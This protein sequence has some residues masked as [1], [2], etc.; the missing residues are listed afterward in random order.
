MN[1]TAE[2][3]PMANPTKHPMQNPIKIKINVAIKSRLSP[4][5]RVDV[6]ATSGHDEATPDGQDGE[7]D[8]G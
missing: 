5:V 3:I 4:F 6:V 2:S 7:E 8:D 1:G